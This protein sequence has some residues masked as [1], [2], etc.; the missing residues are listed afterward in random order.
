MNDA[1]REMFGHFCLGMLT[2]VVILVLL[3]LAVT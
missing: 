1:D 2:V 3:C